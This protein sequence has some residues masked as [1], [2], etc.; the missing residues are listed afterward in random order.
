MPLEFLEIMLKASFSMPPDF[1]TKP[2][3]PGLYSLDAMMFSM[4]PAVLPIL[5]A[6]AA[7]PPTVAGPM[8]VFPSLLAVALM[9]L[10]C[11]S[12]TPSAMTATV[13]MVF[14]SRACIV[15]S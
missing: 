7:M 8:I 9:I 2:T 1:E 14:S 13:R 11:L 10:D 3:H 5:K 15:V 6:P 12:G 4:V